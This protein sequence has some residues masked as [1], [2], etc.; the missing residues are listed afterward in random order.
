MKN[1]L[2]I[3]GTEGYPEENWFPWLKKQLEQ[4][5]Y[6]VSVPKFPTPK[7]QTP[8]HWFE[9]LKPYEQD[10]NNGTIL[11]GHSY[12]GA[13]LL[14][15]LEKLHIKIHAAVFVAASAG[16]KPIKYYEV[17][18]PLVEPEFD[19]RKIRTSAKHFFVFHSEDDPFICVE[20]GEKIAKEVGA[21]LIRLKDAG[22]FN[23]RSGYTKFELLMEKLKTIL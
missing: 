9:T 10:F 17:D 12:G 16:I 3:H 1:A 5:G 6:K 23:A 20:N 4:Y 22:H 8:K 19:W 15:I 13:F 7:N 18:R 11:I 14:R 2:I 21:E